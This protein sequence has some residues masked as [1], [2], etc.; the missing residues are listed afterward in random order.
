MKELNFD[1]SSFRR[2]LFL[3]TLGFWSF[4]AISGQPASDSFSSCVQSKL[5]DLQTY[6]SQRLER[7]RVPTKKGNIVEQP[8]DSV[9]AIYKKA[10]YLKTDFDRR[11]NTIAKETE[12]EA[13]TADLK[14]MERSREKVKDKLL[15]QAWALTDV[16]R[17]TIICDRYSQIER[18]KS[19]IASRFADV[20]FVDRFEKPKPNGYRDLQAIVLVP[21]PMKNEKPLWA[22]IQVQLRSLY[23]AKKRRGDE[24]YHR[25]RQIEEHGAKHPLTPAQISEITR[26]KA[27]E[28]KLYER[29][30]LEAK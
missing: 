23:D 17:G 1:H 25:W 9:G 4:S 10:R 21:A 26:L 5:Q 29:A 12:T 3:A 18:V 13:V 16:M 30:L 24:L 27:Q 8:Y 2:L 28:Q 15:G 14:Q 11:L 7:L 6:Y 19:A 20:K 22:E